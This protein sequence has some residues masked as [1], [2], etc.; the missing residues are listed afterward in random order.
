MRSRS[1]CSGANRLG[2]GENTVLLQPLADALRQQFMGWQCRLRQLAVREAGGRPSAGMRPQVLTLT[3]ESLATAITVLIIPADP[4]ETV[5]LFQ[6]QALR[7]QDPAERYDKA[8]EYLAAHYY[9]R[10]HEFSDELTALFAPDAALV[11]TL[12]QLGQCRLEF[13]QYTHRYRLP[14]SVAELAVADARFLATYWHNRLFNPNLPAGV[15]V[16]GFRPEWS[17]ASFQQLE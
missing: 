11:E 4:T 15:R 2:V 16:L 3:E 12:L 7:T 9:Q 5:K 14:C 17:H 13:E 8:L 6:Y 10:P 1:G